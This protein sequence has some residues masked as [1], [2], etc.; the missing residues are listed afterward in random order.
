MSE[1]K[2]ESL[3]QA[4]KTLALLV[5]RGYPL[6]QAVS[7]ISD[8]HP[9]WVEVKSAVASGDTVGQALRRYPHIFSTFFSGLV[10]S[11][12]S[13]PN[14]EA[15]L[16]S[17]SLWL[18]TA[19]EVRRKVRELLYYPLLLLSF[20]LLE[21]AVL[22]GFAL[23]TS[24]LPFLY[25]GDLQRVQELD[26]VLTP[27]AFLLLILA[28]LALLASW[29]S[30]WVVPLAMRIPLFRATVLKADQALWSRAVACYLQAGCP[31]QE[32]LKAADGIVW[33][34]E[35]E[36]ELSTLSASLVKGDT[37]SQAIGKLSLIDP[38]LRWSITAG[39]S[40][41]DLSATL[42]YAAEQLECN[43]LRQAR[44]FFL[45]L[46][47]MAIAVVGLMTAATLGTFWWSFYH[48]SWNLTL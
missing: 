42:F 39:E 44:A 8:S 10:Q 22:V 48:Y 31:L 25:M 6:S 15:I 27:V 3:R 40:K 29:R 30:D 32:A 2:P 41:E 16:S 4:V 13:T 47:P 36:S 9:A 21:L 1:M 35:L 24:L 45:L 7:S 5:R 33:S 17:L 28:G 23:P 34:S 11:A 37:L 14:G 43:L 19:E 46:Q 38:G 26:A 20:L 18:E 12:E